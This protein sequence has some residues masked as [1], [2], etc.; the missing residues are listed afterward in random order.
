[1]LEEVRG[2]LVEE[3]EKK[4]QGEGEK[5]KEEREAER[6]RAYERGWQG[7]VANSGQ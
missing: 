5:V 6:E 4:D 7:K 1:M 3:R 2:V